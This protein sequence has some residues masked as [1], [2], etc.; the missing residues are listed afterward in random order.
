MDAEGSPLPALIGRSAVDLAD[1]VR[2]REVHP[3][4]V[5]EQHLARIDDL[6]DLN[7]VITVDGDRAL[8]AAARVRPG[9]LA[10]VPLLVKDALDTAGLRT[11]YGSAIFASHVPSRTA[12]AVRR[13]EEAGAIVL[14]KANMHEFAWGLTSQNEHWGNVVNPADPEAT[15]G[16][17]SGGNAAA[18]RAGLCAAG[19][20]TDTAGSIRI[21]A[22]CCGVVGFKPTNGS[23]PVDGVRP[24][25]PS[26]DSVGP[27]ARSVHDC[28][29]VWRV[30]AGRTEAVQRN[31]AGIRAGVIAEAGGAARLAEAGVL[32]EEVVFPEP[33]A[34]DFAAILQHEAVATH[35]D[36][37]PSRRLEL[38]E[39]ARRKWDGAAPV[40]TDR[41]RAAR[42]AVDRWRMRIDETLDHDVLVLPTLGAERPAHDAA[43]HEV[44]ERLGRFTRLANHLGWAALAIGDLQILGRS[45]ATVLA[46]GLAWEAAA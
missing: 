24:L 36:V 33:P 3:V 35:E 4:E 37:Y 14:G 9:P 5:V 27:M 8:A 41:Y 13:L 31:V 20:A 45:D 42:L 30:L 6:R 18:L 2:L 25:A 15:P 16:G 32:M 44:R 40:T 19:V 46:A 26:L 17:S 23:I 11:T 1:L 12:V 43:E 34:A 28:V 29:A 39:D 22:A 10:G 21:P 38:G 7:A